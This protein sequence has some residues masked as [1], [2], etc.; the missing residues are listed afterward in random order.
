[1]STRHTSLEIDRVTFTGAG[2][3]AVVAEDRY[4]A[5]DALDLI[6]VDYE[7]LPV[8]VDAAKATEPGAPQ[9]HENAA[10]NIVFD[11]LCGDQASTDSVAA[12]DVVVKRRI[13][14]QR[15]LPTPLEPHGRHCPI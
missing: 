5:A 1:M 12:A 2:V 11:W 14:N 7:P 15:L 6:E 4:Q 13:I 8:V 10:N 3:A 9:L